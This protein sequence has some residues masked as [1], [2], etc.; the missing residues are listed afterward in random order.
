MAGPYYWV[1]GSGTWDGS[2][3]TH[4]STSSGGSNGAGPPT[5]ADNV[6]FDTLANATG[7]TLTVAAGAVCADMTMGAPLTGN[8]T[9]N[10]TGVALTIGGSLTLAASGITRNYSGSLVFTATTTGKTITTNGV[11]LASAITFDGVGGGWT[12]GSALTS[13]AATGT[14]LTNGALDLGGF[15]FTCAVFSSNNSNTRSI[16]FN[17]AKIVCTAATCWSCATITNLAITG[18]PTVE[19]SSVAGTVQQWQHGNSAGGSEAN[20]INAKLGASTGSVTLSGHYGTV[21]FSLYTA[22]TGVSVSARTIYNSLNLPA[23]TP[24]S[25]GVGATTLGGSAGTKT[26]TS[27]GTTIDFPI[28]LNATGATWQLADN[29]T[30]GS[31]RNLTLTAGTLDL[32]GKTVSCQ[33][34]SSNNSNVRT[35]AFGTGSITVNTNFTATT[36]TNLTVTYSAGAKISMSSASSKAFTG[37]GAS[38]PKLE[39]SGAGAVTFGSSNNTFADITTTVLPATFTFTSGTTQ[40]FTAFSL[41]GTAG[42]LCTI[43]SSTPGSAAT[44]SKSSGTVTVTYCDLTDSAATGGATWTALT[45][46]GNTNGGGN[47][48]WVFSSNVVVGTGVV[49]FAY[50]TSGLVTGVSARNGISGAGVTV[51]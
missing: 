38:W 14:T 4:W 6:I 18:T 34:F 19:C 1:G 9:W 50:T 47:T 21:D 33:T 36:A 32:N 16:A 13:T 12:L 25:A 43:N 26:L 48:G 7:Y 22:G 41:S 8:I 51:L 28:T 24:F 44:L 17:S 10:G 37:G 31:T 20:A 29:L 15:T 27:N 46:S 45:A 39:N 23:A 35:L 2:A 30:M 42:N 5:S 3:T 49:N 40:T 11:S